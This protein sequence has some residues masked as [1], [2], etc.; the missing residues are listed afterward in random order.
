[1]KV[2]GG[3]IGTR[4]L[5]R[6]LTAIHGTQSAIGQVMTRKSVGEPQTRAETTMRVKRR[7]FVVVH[8]G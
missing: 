6:S 3:V 2:G 7:L 8:W 4:G 5:V 1:M